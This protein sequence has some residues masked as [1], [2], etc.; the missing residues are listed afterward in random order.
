MILKGGA[1]DSQ[2][3]ERQYLENGGKIGRE[4]G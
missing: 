1:G 3:L 4:K 2:T